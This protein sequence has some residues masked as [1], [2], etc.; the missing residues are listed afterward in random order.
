MIAA[1]HRSA[2]R[3]CS[4]ELQMNHFVLTLITLATLTAVQP[5]HAQPAPDYDFQWATIGNPGNPA[6]NGPASSGGFPAGRGSVGYTYRMSKLEVTTGQWMEYVNT[7]TTQSDDM[8][9]FLRQPTRWGGE[10]DL[11]YTGPGR[12]YVLDDDAPYGQQAAAMAPVAGVS[13]RDAARYCNWLHNGKST[14]PASLLTGAYDTSTWGPGPLPGS[15][16]DAEHHLPGARFW[17]P[18]QDEWLKAAHFDPNKG[19]EGEAGWW[20]FN[21]RSDLAGP[22]SGLPGI[23]QTSGETENW[24]IPLS[25]YPETTSAYG[26][27]DLSGGASEWL[28]DIR[29]NSNFTDRR[30]DG[31]SVAGPLIAD[32]ARR[33]GS[34]SPTAGSVDIGLRIA[35]IPSPS[36]L[37][38]LGVLLLFQRRSR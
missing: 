21:N 33:S 12:R 11:G 32:D 4:G 18:T 1:A 15:Y 29:V 35:S 16:T 37:G 7:F 34:D 36:S 38:M 22:I 25:A 20:T 3:T 13:W 17:I 8:A 14:D 24:W 19:G 6:Y 26:L 27:L 30:W 23:G 10:S 5:T 31:S 2:I 28:E 9:F